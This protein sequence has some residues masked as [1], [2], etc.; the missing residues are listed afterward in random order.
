MRARAGAG[1]WASRRHARALGHARHARRAWGVSRSRVESSRVGSSA[2]SVRARPRA[3]RRG[4]SRRQVANPNRPCSFPLLL[5]LPLLTLT[6]KHGAHRSLV[7]R[8][9]RSRAVAQEA[10]GTHGS[11]TTTAACAH[12]TAPHRLLPSASVTGRRKNHSP[13]CAS[14]WA[15]APRFSRV[16]TATR[17]DTTTTTLHLFHFLT[18][19]ATPARP[20]H[21]GQASRR[22]RCGGQPR[23]IAGVVV[24]GID[25]R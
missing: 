21:H 2:A 17:R 6:R 5:I 19:Y 11:R 22:T 1:A 18:R 24:D 14:G 20:L 7:Q 16:T 12:R 9:R 23:R 25:T 4:E 13:A 15:D 10:H 8:R 3:C